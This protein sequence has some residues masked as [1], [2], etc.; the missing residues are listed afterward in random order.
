[1]DVNNAFL[2]GYLEEE[3]YMSPPDGYSVPTGHVCRLKRSL[4]GLKQASRQWNQEFT[5][6]ILAFGFRQSKH[7]YCLFTKLSDSSFLVLLL[8]VDDILVAGSSTTMID[9]VKLYLDRLF[10][11][12]DLGVAKYFL[13]LEVARSPQGIVVTQTKYIKD[14]VVDTGMTDARTTTTPLPPSIK[15][16][17]NAGAELAHPDIYRRLVGR[18]LYLNFTRPDTSYACQQL[19]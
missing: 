1:M 3:I 17:S 10:T 9:E 15:F 2:H 6:Q 8:Y 18:L 13:G 12:K 19:C 14:I 7:D 11:I 5:T 16:T 4:Y